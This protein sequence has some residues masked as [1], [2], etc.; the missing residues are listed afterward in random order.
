MQVIDA[1]TGTVLDTQTLSS[2]QGGEY[3]SWNL[4]GN[5]VI[6]VTNLNSRT[7][8]V[9]SGIFFGGAGPAAATLM[10]FDLDATD[11]QVLEVSLGTVDFVKKDRGA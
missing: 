5:V 9:V 4:S 7:N 8:A 1:A 3:L 6:K 2:F 11:S 10:S